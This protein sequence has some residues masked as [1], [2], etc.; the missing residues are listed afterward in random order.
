MPI[1]W[2][3]G[4]MRHSTLQQEGMQSYVIVVN[5]AWR[6]GLLSLSKGR[7]NLVNSKNDLQRFHVQYIKQSGGKIK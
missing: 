6:R 1:S 5:D 2:C 7:K 3:V 4:F